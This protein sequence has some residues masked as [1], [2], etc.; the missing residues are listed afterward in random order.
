MRGK[1]ELE[2]ELEA[3]SS[4]ARPS[5][6]FPL[7]CLLLMLLIE[8]LMRSQ[9]RLILQDLLAKVAEEVRLRRS[10]RQDFHHGGLGTMA[11]EALER[12]S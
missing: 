2:L 4:P 10:C 1:V 11:D 9:A 5:S 7:L 12:Q 8:A 6:F 3:G